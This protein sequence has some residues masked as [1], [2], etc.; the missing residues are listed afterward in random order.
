MLRSLLLAAV[1]LVAIQSPALAQNKP[2]TKP[3]AKTVAAVSPRVAA[4]FKAS[5]TNKDGFLSRAEIQA[6][7]RR[8]DVGK[9][10]MSPG[11]VEMLSQSLFARADI[12]KDNKLSPPEMQRSLVAMARRYDTNGDGVVSMA[13]RQAAR[14][15]TLAEVQ[16]E[17]PRK[18]QTE[19]R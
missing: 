15:A 17:S 12:N 11:Q 3:G 10:K 13:E 1:A 16:G 19:T 18:P 14:S 9:T 8:M 4:E 7:V 2:A 6:R 5:D